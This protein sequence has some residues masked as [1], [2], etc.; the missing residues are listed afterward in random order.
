MT[1]RNSAD[2]RRSACIALAMSP[3]RVAIASWG[4]SG[5]SIAGVARNG[6]SSGMG[7]I[8]V[9]VPKAYPKSM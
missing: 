4:A 5:P 2:P 6:V 3:R 7:R 8:A 9:A 1:P